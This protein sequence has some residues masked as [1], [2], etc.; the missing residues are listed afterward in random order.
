M[1]F[2]LYHNL[3]V[4]SLYGQVVDLPLPLAMG[5]VLPIALC[6]LVGSN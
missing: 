4:Q 2:C 3:G 5:K 1:M 6:D